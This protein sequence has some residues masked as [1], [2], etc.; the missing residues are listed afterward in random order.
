MGNSKNYFA[1][2]FIAFYI[3]AG[4]QHFILFLVE[5]VINF[6]I[7]KLLQTK[8]TSPKMRRMILF[9]GVLGNLC[10]L[11]YYKY[12]NFFIDNMNLFLKTNLEIHRFTVPLGISFITFQQ[13]AFLV[14]N[15]KRKTSSFS[16]VDY[17]LFTSFFPHIS[18]GPILLHGDF[19][20]LIN[21][22]KEKMNW[23]RLSS[24]IYM[25]VMG[26]GKKYLLQICLLKL[27]IGDI[28]TCRN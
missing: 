8:I 20:P 16:F 13:I 19:F 7:C 24:G 11:L 23:R 26:L 1:G 4:W 17:S 27:S 3:Y 10:L 22:I 9:S 12:F 25:F 5:I 15:Y 2:F 14:D 28:P 21:Q 18:S 6:F